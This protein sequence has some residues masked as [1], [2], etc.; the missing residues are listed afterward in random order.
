MGDPE[1]SIRE[2]LER[3][4]AFLPLFRAPGFSPGRSN[5][6]EET[7][8]GH[9]T[10]PYWSYSSEVDAFQELVYEDG[11]VRGD[12]AWPTWTDSE[13]ARALRDDPATLAAA[14]PDQLAKLLTVV[15]RQDRFVEGTL[16]SAF[17]SGLLLAIVERAA[18]L[19]ADAEL[20]EPRD[21]HAPC[22]IV[23]IDCATDPKNVG[24]ARA[25]RVGD[26]WR[27][28]EIR[29]CSSTER[30]EALVVAWLEQEP[31]SLLALDAPLGWPE[32][33]GAR[34]ASHRAGDVILDDRAVFFNRA[35]DRFVMKV[36]G[37]KP[38]DV[39]AD[40]IARTAHA[41]LSLLAE[42]RASTGR[43]LPL[44]WT[45]HVSET[46]A[47]VEVYPA[48]TLLAHGL[49]GKGF[50]GQGRG[51][52]R[53]PIQDMLTREF[54]PPHRFDAES[55]DEHQLDAV[56]CVLAGVDFLR[57]EALPPVDEELA[58]REGWIWVKA[59]ACRPA[60]EP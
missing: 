11:W 22:R 40:R 16:A 29:A 54:L 12:F 59:P 44:S 34:L 53:R 36:Y 55:M 15:I 37:K 19:A 39:G 7:E 49:P 10:M 35:T 50:R 32:A 30:P 21:A 52:A 20:Q 8:P 48:A 47:A 6:F 5:G 56:L 2:R 58:V 28:D 25:S 60:E 23:G 4:A 42:V 24:L 3:L 41:A 43:A 33:L 51:A 9:F 14:T 13:E 27:I 45:P 31:R 17:E 1:R 46:P 18:A 57:G 38:L 26:G